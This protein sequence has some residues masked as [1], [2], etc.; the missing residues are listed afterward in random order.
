MA[1]RPRRSF[2]RIEQR[3]S[4]CRAAYVGPD[5]VVYNAPGTFATRGQAEGWL[6]TVQREI[7][8]GTWESPKVVEVQEAVETAKG[9]TFKEYATTWLAQRTLKPRTR[10][11]YQRLLDDR[12]LPTFGS[13]PVAA[14]TPFKVKEWHTAMG[15]GTPTRRAHAYALLRTILGE[16]VQDGLLPANPCHIRGAGKSKR[17]KMIKPATLAELEAIT[18]AMPER[19]RLMVLLAAWCGLRFGELTE[20]R[21]PDVDLANE[22]LHIRRGVVRVDGEFVVG[23][24]K[25]DAGIRDVAIPPHLVPVVRKHLADNITGGRNGLLFPAADGVSHMAP[26]T[27]QTV[28]YPARAAAGRP[29]LRFHD[30]RHTGAVLAASTGATLAEL[31]ARLGHS[32]VDAAMRYQHASKDRDKVIAAALSALAQQT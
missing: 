31:M 10:D 12:V 32:T 6:A 5:K 13:L 27:L 18:E 11:E 25:S 7:D 8:L 29:D 24:P 3:G 28:W 23:P 20:L 26:S 21:R 4:R 30:L 2:G 1:R 15:P 14:I 9:T 19:Y 16:A 22:T 17:V